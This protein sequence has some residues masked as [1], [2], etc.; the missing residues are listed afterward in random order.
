MKRFFSNKYVATFFF[1]VKAKNNSF[2]NF[3]LVPQLTK[4]LFKK[5]SK[6]KNGQQVDQLF[7]FP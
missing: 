7:F 4:S 3:D 2:L 6:N 1:R 5:I